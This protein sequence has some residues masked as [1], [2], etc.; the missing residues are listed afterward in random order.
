VIN[1]RTSR[2]RTIIKPSIL[3]KIDIFD[4]DIVFI[5]GKIV[6]FVKKNIVHYFD[7][8]LYISAKGMEFKDLFLRDQCKI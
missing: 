2:A 4:Y 3:W 1:S 7:F 5:R 8:A 6:Y